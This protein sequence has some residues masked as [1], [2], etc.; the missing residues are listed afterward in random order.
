M[1]VEVDC[2]KI[3]EEIEKAMDMMYN[4]GDYPSTKNKFIDYH[5][6]HSYLITHK[7]I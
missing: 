2:Q 1:Q 4:I 3:V 7:V 6:Y 5:S